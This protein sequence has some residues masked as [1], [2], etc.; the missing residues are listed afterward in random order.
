M[1]KKTF[2]FY[3]QHVIHTLSVSVSEKIKAPYVS[4]IMYLLLRINHFSYKQLLEKDFVFVPLQL[5]SQTIQFHY[6]TVNLTITVFVC[7]CISVL[8]WCY[9]CS[10]GGTYALEITHCGVFEYSLK[11]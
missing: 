4:I 2:L 9:C 3:P 1:L 10:V 5:F 8:G 7:G 11:L 6:A